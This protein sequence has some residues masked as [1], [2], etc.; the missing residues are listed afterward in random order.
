MKDLAWGIYAIVLYA[1]LT[2]LFVGCMTRK[3][4]ESYPYTTQTFV[5]DDIVYNGVGITF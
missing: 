3:P 5:E 2:F 1:V 4:G